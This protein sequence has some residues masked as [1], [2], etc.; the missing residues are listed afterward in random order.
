MHRRYD[1][2]LNLAAHS[3]VFCPMVYAVKLAIRSFR[4]S[5]GFGLLAITMLGL[6]IGAT[7]AMFS[8][9]HTVLLKP[10]AYREPVRLATLS[11]RVPQFSRELSPVPLN[12]HHYLLFRNPS[13]TL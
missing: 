1:E 12:A 2:Y 13:R 6:G 8:I 10:L 4:R 7:T 3:S 11:F 9:T 5:P